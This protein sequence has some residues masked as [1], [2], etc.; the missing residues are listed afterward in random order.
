MCLRLTLTSIHIY[1]ST[2][3]AIPY[4]FTWKNMASKQDGTVA[5]HEMGLDD[6][7]LKVSELGEDWV[8]VLIL[9]SLCFRLSLTQAGLLQL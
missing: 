2:R 1:I 4:H 3:Q 7:I 9:S 8:L 5:F 6:R